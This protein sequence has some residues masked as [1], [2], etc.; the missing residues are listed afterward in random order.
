MIIPS[1]PS[2]ASP[3]SFELS[4]SNCLARIMYDWP[5]A[6]AESSD[7][8]FERVNQFAGQSIM[9]HVYSDHENVTE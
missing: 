7:S 9:Q 6:M 5:A 2:L 4:P 1:Q 3:H 8:V